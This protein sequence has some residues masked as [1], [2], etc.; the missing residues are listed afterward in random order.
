M[1]FEPITGTPGKQ[2]ENGCNAPQN[3]SCRSS[4][5]VRL[6]PLWKN[7]PATRHHSKLSFRTAFLSEAWCFESIA[8]VAS[9]CAVN[10]P[11]PAV[12]TSL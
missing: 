3:D 4:G 7:L 10:T 11:P 9:I 5:V 12:A 8:T 2:I 6:K 1:T